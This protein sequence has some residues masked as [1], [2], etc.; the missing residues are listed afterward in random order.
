MKKKILLLMGVFSLGLLNAQIGINTD[1]PQAL[2]HVKGTT[3]DF[4]I[5]SDGYVG[6]G[7]TSPAYMLDINT[8]GD[9][10]IRVNSGSGIKGG[11]VL[12]SD[13]NGAAYWASPLSSSTIQHGTIAQSFPVRPDLNYNAPP[14]IMNGSEYTVTQPGNYLITMRW[15][16]TSTN[17]PSGRYSTSALF[18]LRKNY[19]PPTAAPYYETAS[20][21]DSHA[22][23]LAITPGTTVTN[24]TWFCFDIFF[25][26]SDLIVGDKLCITM[27]VL[28]I[29]SM[30]K[31]VSWNSG[32]AGTPSVLMP[33]FIYSKL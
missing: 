13:A 8:S 10:P 4:V 19:T 14:P 5:S 21:Q 1:N 2:F 3:S 16:G 27:M 12:S 23:Y 32:V 6:S 25:L 11:M 31:T 26:A 30:P 24:T 29:Y 20:I 33:N 15:W 28:D 18:D 17:M 9:V 7:T 22:Y